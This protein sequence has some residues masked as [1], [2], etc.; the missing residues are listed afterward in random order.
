MNGDYGLIYKANFHDPAIQ[1]PLIVA[2]PRNSNITVGRASTALVELMDVGVTLADYASASYPKQGLGRSL[3]PHIEERPIAWRTKVV[4]EFD[5]HTCVITPSLKV[6]FDERFEPVLAF[7]RKYDPLETKD[8]SQEPDYL[9]EISLQAD[10]LSRF[11]ASTP[12]VAAVV[13][14]L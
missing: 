4:S 7:D 1:L 9:R 10:W 2:P 11:R 12:M 13:P 3:R 8:V 14:D 6:E 5:K